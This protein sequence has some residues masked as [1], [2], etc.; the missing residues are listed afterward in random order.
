MDN[1]GDQ[2]AAPLL[3][4]AFP[5]Y[6]VVLDD[7]S[8][9]AKHADCALLVFGGGTL[10]DFKILPFLKMRHARRQ[11]MVAWGLGHSDR[12]VHRPVS[13]ADFELSLHLFSLFGTRDD[14][15]PIPHVPCS[16]CMSELFDETYPI[17]HEVVFYEHSSN[18][19]LRPSPG[20][21]VLG[22]SGIRLARALEFLGSGEYIVTSSYHGVYWGVLLGRKVIAVPYGSKFYNFKHDVPLCTDE[23]AWR[24]LMGHAVAYP[25]ALRESRAVNL[26]FREKV[27]ALLRPSRSE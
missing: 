25:Q 15:L 19:P 5:G 24:D 7:Y 4:F 1:V 9:L 23:T 3:Y 13:A 20:A 8:N 21:P 27:D 10:P 14:R 17:K 6:E 22:N 12:D 16:S 26:A 11:P 2:A 18:R